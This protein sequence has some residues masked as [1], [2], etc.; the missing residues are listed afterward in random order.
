MKAMKYGTTGYI[1]KTQPLSITTH[2][3][4]RYITS[5]IAIYSL[6]HG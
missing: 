2:V 6:L 5:R 4:D 3:S 1:D